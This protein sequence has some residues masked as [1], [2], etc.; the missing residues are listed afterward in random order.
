MKKRVTLWLMVCLVLFGMLGLTA[1][2]DTPAA[3][4]PDKLAAPVLTLS[5]DSVT[6]EANPNADKFEIS[7]DGT[8]SYVESSVNSKKLTDGQ[9]IKVRAVG[10]GTA[11]ATSEWSNSVT[12]TA[13]GGGTGTTPQQLSAPAVS[14]SASG[15]ATWPAVAHASG[16]V[17][18]FNGG[19]QTAT[20]ERSVQ[21]S[22]G[23]SI[24]V[25]AVDS[26]GAYTDSAFSAALTYTGTPSADPAAPDYLGILASNA[27]PSAQ[28]GLPELSLLSDTGATLTL[29]ET[30]AAFL[31][32]TEN[33]MEQTAPAA[34]PYSVYSASGRTVYIQIWLN[35]P[36]QNTILSLKLNGT[37]YQSGGALQS[38]FVKNG[39]TYLNCVYVAV[40]IPGNCYEEIA[41]QVTEIEYVEG[42]NINQDGK[43]VL[44]DESNDTVKIGLPYENA[45]PTVTATAEQALTPSAATLPLRL[46]DPD[47]LITKTGA[48][49]R[50]LL[51]DPYTNEILA[52][53]A[54]AVGD[55]TVTFD[56]LRASTHYAVIAVL[57]GDLRD[58]EGVVAHSLYETDFRTG[59]A[60]NVTVEGKILQNAANGKYYAALQ[61]T[62]EISDPAFRFER[63]EI[64]EYR[65]GEENLKYKGAFEGNAAISEN[66][67]ND[68][69][70][71][72]R[73]YYKNAAGDEQ[74]TEHYAYTERLEN[75]SI[76]HNVYTY[77]LINHGILGFEFPTD[78]KYNADNI[79]VRIWDE[80]SKQYIAKD[81]LYLLN[82]PDIVAQLEQQWQAIDRYTDTDR[83][84]A[85]YSEWNRLRGVESLVAEKYLEVSKT[86]WETLAAGSQYLYVLTYGKDA[87]FF[88]GKN[89]MYYVMLE[90]FQSKRASEYSLRYE[91]VAD[92]DYNNGEGVQ[93]ATKLKD[94]FF[95]I[96]P[97]LGPND[98]MFV[99]SDQNYQPLFYVKDGK[100]HLEVMTRNNMG[101][102]SKIARGYVNQVLLVTTGWDSQT[103]AVLWS[104][105]DP[106][107]EI[108]EA[109]WL[110]NV[111]AALIAGEDVKTAFPYGNLAP[112]EFE[113]AP[114][115]V[116]AGQYYIR[117]TYKM[118]GKTY[119]AEH[120]YDWDGSALEY[121]VVAPLPK[122]SIR[123]ERE[124][125]ETYG[126][127]E[128]VIPQSVQGGFWN[129]YEVEI[130]N[131]ND[132]LILTYTEE[133][134]DRARLHVGYSIRV[135]LLAMDGVNHY[136]D[137]EW[138]DWIK[139]E[140]MKLDAPREFSQSYNGLDIVVNWNAVNYAVKYVYTINDGAEQQTTECH[141]VVPVGARIKVKAVPEEGSVFLASDY[142][143]S[144]TAVESRTKLAAPQVSVMPQDDIVI[145]SWDP[146]ENALRYEVYDVTAGKVVSSGRA[147]QC[148]A[149][150]GHEYRIRAIPQNYEQYLDS[151]TVTVTT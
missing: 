125:P 128:V 29:K 80:Q 64:Y 121:A 94:G 68:K 123:I 101:D 42:T 58:G 115:N 8:L 146:V 7:L 92:M 113:I 136:T 73:V 108:N 124:Y 15:L 76:G 43:A 116:P 13:A 66:I 139:C 74:Y 150:V 140:A 85:V 45:I 141:A 4:T 23:Q 20:T 110:A 75:P 40:T 122:A 97:E 14:I 26:T 127:W 126:S 44:I 78:S 148:K 130:R 12:Y 89:G 49:V 60:L 88:A 57:Y 133:D 82:N 145:L 151:D 96:K 107:G 33:A 93:T 9:T 11:Y 81:A 120:P 62:G 83:F 32:A 77:G 79:T 30:I 149:E 52:Q 131:E 137:G 106:A 95:D 111:K 65:V 1:C 90:N 34:S 5:G 19:A 47:G 143:V 51:F 69:Q 61:I 25:K 54:L 112:I 28:D 18:Q 86:E 46:T 144:Y 129:N 59:E 6:W 99:A 37:K 10:D 16:Y 56:G 50:V 2:D 72:V 147:T 41:Y 134:W 109:T 48:W 102:E 39:N 22:L 118:Y 84:H 135:R 142:S 38:F 55:A 35:N 91:L 70:Y 21:L 87:N 119:D 53:K 27:Q 132:E 98:Y 67:L 138:S 114:P 63:V 104:Q 117:F 31:G 24:T 100:V 36:L 17:Y 103:V 3:K 105:E 71:V